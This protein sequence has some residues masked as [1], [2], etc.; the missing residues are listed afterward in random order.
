M[1]WDDHRPGFSG[2]DL[3]AHCGRSASDLYSLTVTDICLGWTENVILRR[4]S[5]EDV[6]Q[7]MYSIE[8]RMPFP[9]LGIDSDNGS[10]FI[11]DLFSVSV[12]Q[13]E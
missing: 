6:V 7:A 5:K 1:D 4:K 11:N 3:V 10:E 9:I 12:R 8:K 13:R 2:I